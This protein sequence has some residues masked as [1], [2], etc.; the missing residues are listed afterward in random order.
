MHIHFA[1]I[2]KDSNVLD[3]RPMDAPAF[4]ILA[5]S[6]PNAVVKSNPVA[7][8]INKKTIN[9][10]TNNAIKAHIDSITR[11]GKTSPPNLIADTLCGCIKRLISRCPCFLSNRKRII[12]MPPD[13]DAAQPPN[14]A[15]N[16]IKSGK[17]VGHLLKSVTVKPVV[18]R[19][20]DTVNNESIIDSL[21]GTT[22]YAVRVIKQTSVAN[23]KIFI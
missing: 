1:K 21:F 22:W 9:T 18:V 2:G 16:I 12:L 3:E 20:D 23:I 14:N 15:K 13:V 10:K 6:E 5:A 7:N 8:I 17:N 11:S 19:M 4:E